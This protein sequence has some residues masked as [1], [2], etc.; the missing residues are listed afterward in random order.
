MLLALDS[1]VASTGIEKNFNHLTLQTFS[2]L[3][4]FR[5]N[6]SVVMSVGQSTS[7]NSGIT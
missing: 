3:R 2:V 7:V 4:I 5:Y 1:G 6:V